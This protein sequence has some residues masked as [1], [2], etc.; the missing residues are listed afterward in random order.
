MECELHISVSI[1]M[2]TL[3]VLNLSSFRH[4][5]DFIERGLPACG[6]LHVQTSLITLCQDILFS[7]KWK[8]AVGLDQF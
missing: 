4:E 5:D 6:S 1:K 3:I 2:R 8:M 7:I